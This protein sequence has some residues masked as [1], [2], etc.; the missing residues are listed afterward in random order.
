M[1]TQ[2]VLTGMILVRSEHP[3]REL[4]PETE[5]DLFRLVHARYF[6]ATIK[7]DL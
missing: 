5:N 4:R 1:K 2:I 6:T 3:T 7:E